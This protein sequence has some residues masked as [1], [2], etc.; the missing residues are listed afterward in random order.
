MR[1]EPLEICLDLKI[2]HALARIAGDKATCSLSNVVSSKQLVSFP[3]L[4]CFK[5]I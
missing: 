2:A 1:S 4:T 3:L 5:W